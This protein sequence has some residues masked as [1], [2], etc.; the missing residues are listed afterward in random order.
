MPGCRV[1]GQNPPQT[2]RT[3]LSTP[4]ELER[5]LAGVER[6]AYLRARLATGSGDEALDIVQ[7]AMTALATRYADRPSGEWGAL[8]HTILASRIRDW[9]RRH[10]V[11]RR[12]L[13]WLAPHAGDDEADPIEN[14]ADPAGAEPS[15]ETESS[16]RLAALEQ[17][18]AKLPARQRE[19]FLLRTW[20][21]LDV[22]QT[23]E[24]MGCSQGSVKT[25]YSRAVHALRDM[26]EGYMP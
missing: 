17:A 14:L 21:G 5:F 22:A 12:W 15:A 11:R 6:R 2:G 23:A 8:F 26:L 1:T 16:Q 18:L 7:D 25:H 3:A 13:T 20:D 10:K 9:Y 4:A 24:A 19:A